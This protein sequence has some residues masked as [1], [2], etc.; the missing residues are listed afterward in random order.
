MIAL[1]EP[2][3]LLLPGYPIIKS[4]GVIVSPR[5]L[6]GRILS[7]DKAAIIGKLISHPGA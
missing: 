3:R 5:V 4:I 7:D 2:I 6:K 1:D